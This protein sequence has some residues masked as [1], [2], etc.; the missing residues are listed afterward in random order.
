MGIITLEAGIGKYFVADPRKYESD[1]DYWYC[2]H[3][4]TTSMETVNAK[5]VY[6]Q[7]S[8]V[9]GTKDV[10]VFEARNR[11]QVH[12]WLTAR[13]FI[14]N[15]NGTRGTSMNVRDRRRRQAELAIERAQAEIDRLLRLPE[16]PTANDDTPLIVFFQKR[17]NGGK[18]YDYAAIK[19]SDGLWYTT[20][21]RTPKGFTWDELVD[22]IL[23]ERDEN[24]TIYQAKKLKPID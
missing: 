12:E 15:F 3:Q 8:R 23:Q 21:P 13:G 10:F 16:E 19:A 9:S 20:G 6:Q 24:A 4:A 2:I 14:T 1:V 5:L 18:A 17:F 7:R 22:W 11:T